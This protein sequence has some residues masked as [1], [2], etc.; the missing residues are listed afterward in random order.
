MRKYQN[1]EDKELINMVITLITDHATFANNWVEL[2]FNNDLSIP[3]EIKNRIFSIWMT[4][5]LDTI[6]QEEQFYLKLIGECRMREFKNSLELLY[7]FGNLVESLK[8]N[9]RKISKE[10]QLGV[11]QYRNSIVHGRTHSVHN[12][13][14]IYRYFDIELNKTVKTNLSQKDFWKII[15][16]EWLDS[17]DTFLEP[18]RLEFFDDTT[19]YYKNLVSFLKPGFVNQVCEIAYR[20][21]K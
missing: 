7:N 5:C 18:I 8:M 4:G 9:F 16:S 10:Q 15:N 21:L 11:I 19:H 3:P 1:T 14:I 13:R 2:I 6:A 17:L 12:E 20:D